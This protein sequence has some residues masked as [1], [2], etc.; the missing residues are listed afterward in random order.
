MN[1]IVLT[2]T[3]RV[4]RFA[5]RSRRVGFTQAA[6]RRR[7][8]SRR[9]SVSL[10]VPGSL[11]VKRKV[12]FESLAPVILGGAVS[13]GGRL[14]LPGGVPVASSAPAWVRDRPR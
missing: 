9:A 7:P 1:E 2:R 12:A 8:A 3:L 10:A 5:R 6:P 13:A 4:Q 14:P 11:L